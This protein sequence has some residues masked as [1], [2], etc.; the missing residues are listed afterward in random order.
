MSR[1]RRNAVVAAGTRGLPRLGRAP[2]AEAGELRGG[3]RFVGEEDVGFWWAVCL[4][5]ERDADDFERCF[6]A[7]TAE[8]EPLNGPTSI[9]ESSALM[10]TVPVNVVFVPVPA[11]V[12]SLNCSVGVVTSRRPPM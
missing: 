12:M 11:N 2:A 1:L 9:A 6:H 7:L 3:E 5:P 8:V 10:P 4:G